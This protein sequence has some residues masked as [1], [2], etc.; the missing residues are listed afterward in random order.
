MPAFSRQHTGLQYTSGRSY[1]GRSHRT[2]I[3]V[4]V[5]AYGYFGVIPADPDRDCVVPPHHDMGLDSRICAIAG[6]PTPSD[7][8]EPNVIFVPSGL[9]MQLLPPRPVLFCGTEFRL[10]SWPCAEH[11]T[12]D[13]QGSTRDVV[14]IVRQ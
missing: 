14:G 13:M 10:S 11:L 3:Q 8:D 7:V 4:T 9:L 5:T 2:R 12:R 1:A 6:G